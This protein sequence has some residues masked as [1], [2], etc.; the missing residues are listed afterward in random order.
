MK[1]NSSNWF[2]NIVKPTMI[3]CE[4]RAKKNIQRM[5][6]KATS[7]GVRFRPHFKTH[8][9]AQIGEW[10]REC[11]VKYITVSSIEMAAYFADHSWED[12]TI[13]FPVNIREINQIN[14]LAQKIKLHL[15]VESVES[16]RFLRENARNHLYAWMKIDAGYH[17]T[18]ILWNDIRMVTAVAKEIEKSPV[19]S[20]KGILTHSG[21]TYKTSSPEK[22]KKIYLETVERLQAVRNYLATEG[23]GN[24]E[25]SI[26]DTPGCSIVEDF[27]AVDE[28]RPGNFVFYD[29]MQLEI[30][31]CKEDDIAV[32]VACPV[33][34]KHPQRHE[35]VIYG[36][37]V[38][39]SK[40]TL[41]PVDGIPYFGKVAMPTS[42][43]WG[44]F[45]EGTYLKAISQEHGII[46][47]EKSIFP[48]IH[49]GNLLLIIPVHSCLTMNLLKSNYLIL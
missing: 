13:A 12:I 31:S 39:L 46:R 28:I 30:G 45:L 47:I 14:K 1:K 3:V 44:N 8:Q 9:S 22:V 48:H 40:E 19:L 42:T 26:G 17:R 24:L 36:G 27:S 38:H 18:G 7:Y 23:F 4:D 6:K 16:V 15:L 21:H 41:S 20:L 32:G 10:F 29:V 43:G 11:G 34:A 25:V 33:V 5:T 49:V 35:I 2:E 37:A